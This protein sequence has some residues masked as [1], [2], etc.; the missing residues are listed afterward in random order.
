MKI[1]SVR[2][3]QVCAEKFVN[4]QIVYYVTIDNSIVCSK[5]ASEASKLTDDIKPKIFEK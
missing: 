4:N 1:T 2:Y 3:C 5:C